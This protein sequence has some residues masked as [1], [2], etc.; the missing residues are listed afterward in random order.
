MPVG[1]KNKKLAGGGLHHVALLCQ[2]LDASLHL[3]RD[4]LGM[5]A[6]LEF[7]TNRKIVLV[8]MGDG[9]CLELLGPR[10]DGVPTEITASPA[11]PI[12]HV[13]LTTTDARAAIEMVRQAGYEVTIEPKN[14]LLNELHVTNAFFKGPDGELIEFFEIKE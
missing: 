11:H 6:A 7:T 14:L 13:A 4:V 5:E 1:N 2:D 12:A 10:L 3:Y 8:D 9:S